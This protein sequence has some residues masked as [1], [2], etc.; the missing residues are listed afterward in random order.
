MG[1]EM[2]LDLSKC[3]SYSVDRAR[4]AFKTGDAEEFTG[5]AYSTGGTLDIVIDNARALQKRGVLEACLVQGFVG[6]KGKNWRWPMHELEDWFRTLDRSRLRGAGTRLP[7]SLPC[8]I[9]RG[10]AEFA[11]KRVVRGLSWT[12]SLNVACWFARWGASE[13][14][15]V[16]SATLQDD[17]FFCFTDE[18]EE[19]EVIARPQRCIQMKLSDAEILSLADKHKPNAMA[20]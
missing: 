11:G 5:S 18:R 10:V 13:R 12:L 3:D 8:T 14:M 2:K 16:F 9:Y 19:Q 1:D 7:V 20:G 4:E 17:D 6:C 15:F